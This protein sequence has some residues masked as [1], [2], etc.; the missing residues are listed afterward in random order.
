MPGFIDYVGLLLVN[1][2]AGFALLAVYVF[3]GMDGPHHKRWSSAFG[4]V[5]LIA[6]VFGG[7]MATS[8]PLPGAYSLAYG[9]MSVL[10]GGIFLAAAL[11][12]AF[13]WDLLA[14]AGYAFFAGVAAIVLGVRIISLKMTLFPLLSGIGFILSGLAGVCAFPMLAFFRNNRRARALGALVLLAAAAI[15]AATVYPEYWAHPKM[16]EH[17]V[18]LTMR[19]AG[20]PKH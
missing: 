2:T 7:I 19:G 17:W 20:T 6:L 12:I 18:P 1:M 3:K 10:F 5:G 8:W 13:S 14:V 9:E 15:W 16:F 4:L 11:S